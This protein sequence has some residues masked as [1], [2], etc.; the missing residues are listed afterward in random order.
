MTERS[1]TKGHHHV[2]FPPLSDEPID[3]SPVPLAPLDMVLRFSE[4]RHLAV[5]RIAQRVC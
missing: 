4:G 2:S 5:P 1:I 3:S